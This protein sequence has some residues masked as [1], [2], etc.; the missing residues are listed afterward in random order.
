MIAGL[1]APVAVTAPAPAAAEPGSGS[2]I[3][4]I[5][6]E[7]VNNNYVQL[8]A[9]A[10]RTQRKPLDVSGIGPY[11]V[12]GTDSNT[13]LEYSFVTDQH[14]DGSNASHGAAWTREG[15]ERV[16]R[17]G[18][19]G[20]W[21]SNA[22]ATY[23]ERSN[24]LMLKQ[25]VNCLA[26]NTFGGATT[27]C[28]I[29]GPDVYTEAFHAT[30]GQ[31]VS[32]DWAARRISDDYEV[33]AYLVEVNETSPGVYDYGSPATHAILA[34]GRGNTQPW[35]TS[36]REITRAGTY[37]FRFVNGSYDQTG[38]YALGSEMY[39]DSV[40]KVGQANP[41]DFA[42]LGDKVVG[43][44]PFTVSATAPGGAVT[45][46]TA[47]TN[48]CTVSGS[49]V[50][51]TGNT[52]VCTIVADQAGDGAT[53][54][55]AESTARSFTVLAAPTAPTNSG[56]PY[57]SGT[58]A[59]GH[60]VTGNDGTW[61]DGGSPITSTTRQWRVT[62]GG[63][64]T[65]V[66]GASGNTCFL[67]ASAGDQLSFAVTQTNSVGST[68]V[69][70]SL[71]ASGFTCGEP[72]APAWTDQVLSDA[73]QVGVAYTDGVSATG[74]PSPTYSVSAGQLPDGLTLNSS[75]GALTGTPTTAGPFSV[76]ITAS[77]G[78]GGD[79]TV[80]LD[81]AVAPPDAAPSWSPDTTLGDLVHGAVVNTD[82]GADGHPAPTYSVTAGELPDGLTLDPDTGMVTGTASGSG[83]Y[84]FTITATNGIGEPALRQFTGVVDLAPD[85]VGVPTVPAP[86]V[87][88]SLHVTLEVTG[89]PAPTFAVTAG[90]LPD[91]L[92]LDADTGV[93]SGTPT[94][95]GPFEFTITV[96]NG[97][98]DDLVVSPSGTV[99][100]VPVWDPDAE[101]G[102]IE[103]GTEVDVD[104][105]ADGTPAPTYAVTAGELPEGLSLDPDTGVLS[106]TPTGS[107]PY[108]FT[109]TATNGV[110][111][112]VSRQF[113]G[114]VDLAPSWSPTPSLPTPVVGDAL[115]GTMN[116]AAYP[117]PTFTVSAGTLPLGLQL[118]PATGVVSG[119]PTV[120]A[121]YD[122]TITATNGVGDPIT[123]T[124]SGVVHAAAGW[125]TSSL[126]SLVVGT[127][128]VGS[129]V[130]DGYPLPTYSVSA[131]T[132]PAGLKLNTQ[133]GAISGTPTTAGPFSFTV[134]AGNGVGAATTVTMS[135]V[136][137]QA[138]A[139][140]TAV[141]AEP[142]LGLP[143]S[144]DV[145]VSGTPSP[146]YAVTA[147]KLPAGLTL[148]AATGAISGVPAAAGAYAF[149]ITAS[150]GIG[151]DATKAYSGTVADK[152]AAQVTIDLE[153]GTKVGGSDVLVEAS[154]LMARSQV[155]I[156]LHSDPIVLD[157]PRTDAN[158][159]LSAIVTLPADIAPGEHHVV[160]R[161]TTP[162]GEELTVREPLV[163]DWSGARAATTATG[164][165]TAVDPVRVLDTRSASPLTAGTPFELDIEPAWGLPAAATAVTVNVTVT[166]TAAA[167][168]LTVFPCGA[169]QPEAS[170]L[171]FAAG[172]TVPNL[173]V[174][175]VDDTDQLC[176][177]SSAGS[178]LIVDLNGFHAAD[179]GDRLSTQ[180][181]VRS[182]DTRT[183]A[184]LDAGQV[185]TVGV[186]D[187]GAAAAA[188]NLTVTDP[189]AAGYLTAYPCG[190]EV[191]EVSNLNFD[192]GQTMANHANVKLNADGELCLY[193]SA[194]T[195]VV[196]DVS[197]TFGDDG[198][199]ALSV[200]VPGRLFDSRSG[201][202][203]SAGTVHT[204][205]MTGEGGA[206][207]DTT[208]MALNVTVTQ[209]TGDGYLTVFGCGEPPEASN[210]NYLTDGTVANHVTVEVDDS[211][212][213][214]V[215]TSAAIHL[216]V[217]VE[218]TYRTVD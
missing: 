81:G 64:T 25:S 186:A 65:D 173:M 200:N 9:L 207:S 188:V 38:G 48:I 99:T 16:R 37:R 151:A 63:T 192:A 42:P 178:H 40:V 35:T 66:P 161:G 52:G 158:G 80:S 128:A 43:A 195:H 28:T 206:P 18:V 3:Q 167:G 8:G 148:N 95:A 180:A 60:V 41:I 22:N 109:I 79:L 217:D 146:V 19:A 131:G 212:E 175:A 210:V 202:M 132:L 171:N 6:F 164:G 163:V 176:F 120:S 34:H 59:E 191:P 134:T 189:D 143:Y 71:L 13:G 137:N 44:E 193:T 103:H 62:N 26:G 214:C 46:S 119:T 50:T 51:L 216:L 17:D 23:L 185:V 118:D 111:D 154:G 45:F 5:S 15:D 196:V 190:S 170:L 96:S 218:G 157:T 68:T 67:V 184:K 14:Y 106:G 121:P 122:F 53:Y 156:E 74:A 31:A 73:L 138:P 147:G 2:G 204:F 208:A 113:T 211:G 105:G 84:E 139:A 58:V 201:A 94:T 172:Q 33:Y 61:G 114:V 70:S 141:L 127:P 126:G 49:T 149:T 133:S 85:W 101:L 179:G 198:D 136:V 78:F 166:D 181:P 86:V 29:F 32:F 20:T 187:P 183:T 10:S 129:F 55:P 54:V 115:S 124:F 125:T 77:N 110:G 93:L 205:T 12:R 39:I 209:A 92:T 72:E 57:V 213:V 165:F 24:V 1:V 140:I 153:V 75:T 83:P 36:S 130:A 160:V 98:G 47:T 104:L 135:G 82:L 123:H 69:T 91:G 88:E 152:A 27:Y 116:V 56:A 89:F 203:L 159:D 194:P 197:G 30:A 142:V 169:D 90:E 162:L 182:L 174:V 4:Q 199:A 100:A 145:A 117:A 155:S 87:G 97:V 168:Y 112:P 108:A 102:T 11:T 7:A 215:V 150:N 76:T 107:G 21:T 177:T 144:A